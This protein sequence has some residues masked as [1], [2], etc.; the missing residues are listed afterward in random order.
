MTFV[1]INISYYIAQVN[2]EDE[3]EIRNYGRE[4]AQGKVD[5]GWKG[6]IGVVVCFFDSLSGITKAFLKM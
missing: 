2:Q 5:H 1:Y 3:L 4:A 6:V